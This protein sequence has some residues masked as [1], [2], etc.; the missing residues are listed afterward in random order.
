MMR[1]RVE[2]LGRYGDG[3]FPA[4]RRF[5]RIRLCG[6]CGAPATH[7]V[8]HGSFAVYVCPFCYGEIEEERER[9]LQEEE[10]ENILE[11]A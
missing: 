5:A 11:N 9:E 4:G 10:E 8:M 7:K 3:G 6:D 2:E 1:R